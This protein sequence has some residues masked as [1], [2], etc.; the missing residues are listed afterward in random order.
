MSETA[1][2]DA[3]AATDAPDEGLGS[4][5]MRRSSGARRLFRGRLPGTDAPDGEALEE[6]LAEAGAA[7][8]AAEGP[9]TPPR[10]PAGRRGVG[11]AFS[12][13][14]FTSLTRRIL[15]T[16]FAALIAL[17]SGFLYL[18]R[19][20]EEL[21][22][23][24]TDS[25]FTQAEII[26]AAIGA[27]A[28]ISTDAL[29]VDPE[30]LL[31]LEGEAVD[32]APRDLF[33]EEQ[34]VSIDASQ[35]KPVMRRLIRLTYTQ[36]RV[37][38]P[39]TEM[40]LDSNRLYS[41]GE[42]LQY[43]VPPL[44]EPDPP[45]YARAWRRVVLW[46][47]DRNLAL[48]REL[49]GGAGGTY[50]EVLRALNGNKATEERVTEDGQLIISVAVPIKR[51]NTVVGAL[52]LS[53]K[54]GRIDRKLD[55]E[56]DAIIKVFFFAAFVTLLLSVFLSSTI[57]RPLHRLSAAAE[58]VR[59]KV[60]DREEIPDFSYRRDE[61]GDLSMTLRDMTG[62]LYSRI[63]AIE[64]FAA[65]V[66]HE[67]KN[68]LTSLRSAIETLPLAK[69]PEQRERLLEVIE[70]DVQRL[71]RLISDISDA[72]RLD[73]EMAREDYEPVDLAHM[74]RM[75]HASAEQVMQA[76]M[77][78]GERVPR[79]VLNIEGEVSLQRQGR[80]R[81]IDRRRIMVRGHEGRLGQVVSNIVSNARSFVPADGGWIAIDLRTRERDEDSREAVLTIADNG[82]GIPPDKKAK[83]FERF[84]TDRPE[85]EAFGNNSGLGLSI[86][87]QIVEAH[88]GTIR[89]DNWTLDDRFENDLATPSEAR[90]GGA[91]F[92]VTLPLMDR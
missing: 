1:E 55:G 22:E 2:L 30:S 77:R 47:N 90:R 56:R 87:R 92:T 62:S 67:L 42:T 18:D 24:R 58:R 64:R 34:E 86:V 81:V 80:D 52:Q 53:T 89:A 41:T 54:P 35:I 17:V 32:G 39:D 57:A 43:E 73:A 60:K 21:I 28:R 69:R 11:R 27:R 44:A 33:G 5:W 70:H 76:R 48:Y 68:P 16:N 25:L 9:P 83:I 4:R 23:A 12:R 74:L 20:R 63:E 13:Y 61:I 45:W 46:F 15:L 71:D 51:F 7:P 14:V 36:A 3:T 31:Q 85:G 8:D 37:Y 29:T 59:R 75:I 79:L 88:G 49:P 38:G 82:P 91:I 10:A 72:S 50:R 78:A 65:D 26:A 40:L 84:Y 19:F 6:A 66:S